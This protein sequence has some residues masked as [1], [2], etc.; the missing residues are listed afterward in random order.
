MITRATVYQLIAFLA[1]EGGPGGDEP[2][3]ALG[4]AHGRLPGYA[5]G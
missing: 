2:Q 3:R 4:P 5:D 1:P